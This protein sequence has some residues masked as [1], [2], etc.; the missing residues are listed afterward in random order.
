MLNTLITVVV[1]VLMLGF[2]VVIHEGGHYIAARLCGVGIMEFSVGFGPVIFKKKGKYN[3]FT[4]RALPIGGYVSMIGEDDTDVPEEHRGKPSINE[5]KV[6]QKILIVLAGP[7]TNIV[8]GMLLMAVLVVSSSVIGS[9]TVGNF[10]DD[11]IESEQTGMDISQSQNYGLQEDDE[12]IKINGKRIFVY[13]DLAYFI[14]TMGNEPVDL[15]VVR[16]GEQVLLEDV[17]FP[18]TEQNGVEYGNMDFQVYRKEKTFA[19]VCYE[20]FWQPVSTVR[21]TVRSLVD[22]FSG[23]YGISGVSGVVG[24][25]EVMSDVISSEESFRDIALNLLNITV[26]IS[27]SLGI[28]NL[29]PLPALDGGRFV[30]YTIEGIRGKPLNPKAISVAISVSMGLLLLL[31]IL[32]TFK[33]IINLF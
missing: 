1:T 12:I 15:T 24:V 11:A 26:V 13:Y 22:T 6:W 28:F 5:K 20:A 33:D 29:I 17:E 21:T 16:D 7:F 31:M 14:S 10:I 9:T 8:V 32:I 25:G 3:D 23:R 2:L 19:N 4:L 18:V 30:I 27:M